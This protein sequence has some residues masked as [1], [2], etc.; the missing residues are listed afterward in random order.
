LSAKL[1]TLLAAGLL[2]TA[3]G[4]AAAAEILCKVVLNEHMLVPDT[5]VAACLDAGVGNING[6]L[7]GNVNSHDKFLIGAGA[8]TYVFID[9]SDG[10]NQYQLTY[11]SLDNPGGFGSTGLWSFDASAWDD[12]SSLAIGFKFGTGN[13]PDEWF[14]YSLLEGVSSG[15]W[16]FVENSKSGGSGLSHT[17]LYGIPCTTPGGCGGGATVPVPGTLALFLGGFALLRVN[18]TMQRARRPRLLRQA[19]PATET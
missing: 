7:S 13:Q 3:A 12:F 15:T 18:T 16:T 2:A 10:L 8:G 6:N 14:V 4:S 9:K 17:N 1:K 19:G 5:Q 11:T